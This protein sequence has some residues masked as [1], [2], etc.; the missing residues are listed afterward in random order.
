MGLWSLQ[1][2]NFFS[3]G[4]FTSTDGPRTERPTGR[5]RWEEMDGGNNV[6]GS[7]WFAEK[8][9]RA[10]NKKAGMRNKVNFD[11]SESIAT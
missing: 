5:I 9:F 10:S 4:S 1:L 3:G 7:L 8:T 6:G 2:T 11:R